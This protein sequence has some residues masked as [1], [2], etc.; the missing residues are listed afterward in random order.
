VVL[1]VEAMPHQQT[2]NLVQ[3]IQVVVV[4]VDI[5]ASIFQALV[6]LFTMEALGG[7]GL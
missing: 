4:V 7:L 5:V 1:V 2:D 3:Q 6:I